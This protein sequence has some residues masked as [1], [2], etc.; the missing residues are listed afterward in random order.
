MALLPGSAALPLNGSSHALVADAAAGAGRAAIVQLPADLSRSAVRPG[1]CAV[2]ADLAEQPACEVGR[3]REAENVVRY[4]AYVP[5]A[6]VRTTV[7]IA[8]ERVHLRTAAVFVHAKRC[9]GR[10]RRTVITERAARARGGSGL[11]IPGR[12]AAARRARPGS[13]AAR[14]IVAAQVRQHVDQRI[15][16]ALAGRVG[17]QITIGWNARRVVGA[18]VWGH[19]VR[20]N[21]RICVR[22]NRVF[23]R[24]RRS[25][26]P[27]RHCKRRNC[28]CARRALEHVVRIADFT[29]SANRLVSAGSVGRSI[30]GQGYAPADPSIR[31]AS[32]GRGFPLQ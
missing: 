17:D 6:A 11:A 31:P 30:Q 29:M 22:R 2:R 26:A 13:A 8:V 25:A 5:A 7:R 10:A 32:V 20:E 3:A 23:V 21:A 24:E 15:R 12:I 27:K 16:R 28:D 1:V 4:S 9:F 19:D 14:R 18:V